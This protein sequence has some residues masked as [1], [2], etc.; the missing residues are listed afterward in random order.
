MWMPL[1]M[2]FIAPELTAD[3]GHIFPKRRGEV[4]LM[5]LLVGQNLANLLR[6]GELAERFALPHAVAVLANG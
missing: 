5:I 6:H 2:C 1:S 3:I 4:D